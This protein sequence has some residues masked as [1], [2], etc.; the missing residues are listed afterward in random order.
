MARQSSIFKS[1]TRCPTNRLMS[2]ILLWG[3]RQAGTSGR[4]QRPS[5]VGRAFATGRASLSSSNRVCLGNVEDDSGMANPAGRDFHFAGLVVAVFAFGR[6]PGCHLDA[7][8]TAAD[9]AP[10]RAPSVVGEHVLARE[11][12]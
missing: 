1:V 7:M 9:L 6:N 8:L 5:T 2:R 4:W 12:V 10:E 3:E 11:N